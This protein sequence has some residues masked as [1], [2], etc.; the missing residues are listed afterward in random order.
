M[1]DEQF[2]S[3]LDTSLK[4]QAAMQHADDAA[5]VRIF[6]RLN[7][8][9]PSQK[10]HAWSRWPEVLLDWQFAPAWPRMAALASFAVLGF[11]IGISGIDRRIDGRNA[12]NQLANTSDLSAAMFAPEPLTGARP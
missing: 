3:L 9:L 7:G 2:E 5:V 1:T 11:A 10:G 8:P 4:R 6:A 12:R